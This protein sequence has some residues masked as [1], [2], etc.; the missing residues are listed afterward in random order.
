[1]SV[2]SAKKTENDYFIIVNHLEIKTYLEKSIQY[3]FY[4]QASGHIWAFFSQKGQIWVL[5]NEKSILLVISSPALLSNHCAWWHYTIWFIQ[6]IKIRFMKIMNH[7][8][9]MF[10]QTLSF[11]SVIIL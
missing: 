3:I 4:R 9:S 7:D 5:I 2:F 8:V 10:L 6:L 1:M 11:F